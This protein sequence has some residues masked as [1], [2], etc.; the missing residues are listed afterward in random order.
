MKKLF[1]TILIAFLAINLSLFAADKEISVQTDLH[2]GACKAKI[3]K[4]MK[5]LN[6]IKS[7]KADVESKIVTIKYDTDKL[8]DKKI[9]QTIS[10]LGY[11]ASMINTKQEEVKKDD[12]GTDKLKSGSKPKESCCGKDSKR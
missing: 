6:G 11:K 9:I 7:T 5:T 10:D 3:E 2:C 1:L 4:T 12:C 8:S